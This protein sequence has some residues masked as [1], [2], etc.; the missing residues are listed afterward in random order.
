MPFNKA[1][2]LAEAERLVSQKKYAQAIKQYL[3]IIEKDPKDFALLNTA[4]DLCV[5]EGNIRDALRLF[6]RLGEAYV[7]E[8]FRVKAIAIYKKISKLDPQAVDPLLKLGELYAAQKLMREAREQYAQAFEM[9]AGKNKV[10]ALEVM[11]RLAALDPENTD[12]LRRLAQAYEAAGRRAEAAEVYAQVADLAL[13]R[14]DRQTAE[15]AARKAEELGAG[16][17]ELQLMRARLAVEAGRPE[18]LEQ[19]MA[20]SPELA[21]DPAMQELRLR[22]CLA[23]GDLAAA[24]ELAL[25]MFRAQPN[26]FTP[27]ASFCAGCREAGE[28]DLALETL[29]S[30]AEEIVKDPSGPAEP[31]LEAL[32]SLWSARP[33]HIPTLELILR[34]GRATADETMLPEV[35]EALGHAYVQAGRLEEA[36][37]AYRELVELEPESEANRALLQQVLQ[38]A[39]KAPAG[40][41]AET[42]S[43]PEA[44]PEPAF[45]VEE[46]LES[47]ELYSRYGL[48]DKA[49]AELE[50]VLAVYPDRIEIHKRILDLCQEKNP[51]RAARAAE[52]LC[53]LYTQQNS[54]SHARSYAEMARRLAGASEESTL[55]SASAAGGPP[56]AEAAGSAGVAA[57]VAATPPAPEGDDGE[58]DL[59]AELETGAEA[60]PVKPPEPPLPPPPFDVEEQRTALRFYLEYGF[61]DEAREALRALERKFPGDPHVAALRQ[62]VEEQALV[63][64]PAMETPPAE[65]ADSSEAEAPCQDDTPLLPEC[66]PSSASPAAEA[67]LATAALVA[68]SGVEAT[69]DAAVESARVAEELS[70]PAPAGS[71]F[72]AAPEPGL[73][74]EIEPQPSE[75]EDPERGRAEC[76]PAGSET[77]EVEE[78][79]PEPEP[80]PLPSVAGSELP[81]A[82]FARDASGLEAAAAP[83]MVS[84]PVSAAEPRNSEAVATPAL[85]R[86]AAGSSSLEVSLRSLLA[87]LGPAEDRVRRDDA[88]THYHLGVA[89]REM[90]LYDEAISEFQKVVKGARK[91]RLPPRFLQTCS[92]LAHCFMEKRLPSIA[93]KWYLR[94]LEAPD[95]DE[96]ARL[97]LKYELG[98]AYEQAGS[99]EPAL[100]N[101]LEVYSQN[102]EYRDVAERIRLLQQKAG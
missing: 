91:D 25:E 73:T 12:Q 85:L 55:E 99:N 64:A 38:K 11:R 86:R 42:A 1:R 81:A 34:L 33:L 41:S 83:E 6:N 31:L 54:P 68:E 29:A 93:I 88:E 35:L 76:R 87:D 14:G 20:A 36:E 57:P 15:P 50:K 48:V 40:E 45:L 49:V 77:L 90:E 101:Y 18:E 2:A 53:R 66:S 71:P 44:S 65:A 10:Q 56:P 80:A 37:T 27:L 23:S 72:E 62:M 4:G 100:E 26:D 19:I 60:A 47:S 75:A 98:V 13:R 17:L 59:S 67:G 39:G 63:A 21:S 78:V 97:A 9:C 24:R 79:E 58:W 82:C 28:L 94:A 70:F 52:E 43:E 32:R 8:G 30:L 5:R 92:Q 61:V 46:A 22:S 3:E 96:D 95:L 51:A 16:R 84:L 7:A 74:A 69:E 89:F 102:I